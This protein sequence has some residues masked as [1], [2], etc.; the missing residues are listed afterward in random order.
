MSNILNDQ[1]DGRCAIEIIETMRREH[2]RQKQVLLTSPADDYTSY[3]VQLT[4]VQ[5]MGSIIAQ[6]EATYGRFFKV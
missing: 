2:E 6:A 4:T 5:V 3:R 1:R